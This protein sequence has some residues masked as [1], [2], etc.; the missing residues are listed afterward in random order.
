MAVT[1]K[2][3]E[4][5]YRRFVAKLGDRKYK[6]KLDKY[7]CASHCDKVTVPTVSPEIWDK[8]THMAKREDLH[9]EGSYKSW[10]Y[11]DWP[12]QQNYGFTY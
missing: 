2:L 10:G 12:N 7:G 6:E 5:V 3:A 1:A 11:L 4:F 8:L 9:S